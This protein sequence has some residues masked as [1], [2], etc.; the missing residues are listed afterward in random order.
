MLKKNKPWRIQKYLKWI[1]SLPCCV[2]GRT[3][4]IDAHHITFTGQSGMGTKP[5][6]NYAIPLCR[7]QHSLLH[8]DPKKWE[9]VYGKQSDYLD[10]ILMKAN[11]EGMLTGYQVFM[12]RLEDD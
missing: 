11:N 9:S 7:E 4:N 1:R 5:G 10:V 2:T 6:D 3:E 8:Q 12:T